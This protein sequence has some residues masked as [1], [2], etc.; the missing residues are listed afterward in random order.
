ME[1]SLQ[2]SDSLLSSAPESKQNSNTTTQATAHGNAFS[3]EGSSLPCS[4]VVPG[5]LTKITADND[6]SLYLMTVLKSQQQRTHGDIEGW[7]VADSFY[8]ACRKNRVVV[9]DFDW[10]P[11]KA[12]TNRIAKSK[13]DSDYLHYTLKTL[14]WCKV[15][16]GEAVI[17]WGHVKAIRVHVESV[18]RYGL[19]PKFHT[20]FIVPKQGKEKKIRDKLKELYGHLEENMEDDGGGG[21]G[22]GPMMDNVGDYYPYVSVSF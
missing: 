20:V 9:R 21:G 13:L 7:T 10:D 17:A 11:L 19:P 2:E 1:K 16:Y 12:S 4:P 3:L 22:G 8:H 18:L 6:T 5:S 15:H 14:D